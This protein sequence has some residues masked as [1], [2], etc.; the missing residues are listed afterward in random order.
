M[1]TEAS[2]D[3]VWHWKCDRQAR[4]WGPSRD[5]TAFFIPVDDPS[6]GRLLHFL[7][8][9]NESCQTVTEMSR[10]KQKDGVLWG[11]GK[12]PSGVGAPPATWLILI[13]VTQALG[14]ITSFS[15][16]SHWVLSNCHRNVYRSI[17]RQGVTLEMWPSGQGLGPH[18]RSDCIFYRW[19]KFWEITSFSDSAQWVLSNCNRNV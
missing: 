13:K 11:G 5:L 12:W 1:S 16:S 15:K 14:D 18:Q 8:Q 9:H 17:K 3:R 19:P 6:F 10:L 2:K 4:G 7:I